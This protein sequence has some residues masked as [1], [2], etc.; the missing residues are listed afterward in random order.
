MKEWDL[1]FDSDLVN[2]SGR[3]LVMAFFSH[4]YKIFA[5]HDFLHDFRAR[6]IYLSVRQDLFSICLQMPT[7]M[8]HLSKSNRLNCSHLISD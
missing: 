2:V 7:G 3:V 1:A 4:N 6:K 8:G 5:L